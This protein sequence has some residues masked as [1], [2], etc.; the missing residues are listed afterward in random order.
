MGEIWKAAL[1]SLIVVHAAACGQSALD[2]PS[3]PDPT[4]DGADAS[5][6]QALRRHGERLSH[7]L[8]CVGCHKSDFTG[9]PF[10]QG[11]VAPNLSLMIADYDDAAL[12]RAIRQG[13]ARDGRNIKMMPSEMYHALSDADAR[14]LI[15]FL[16]TIEPA[17][18]VRPAFEPFPED[19]IQWEADG[20][21][22]APT[23]IREWNAAPGPL[24]LEP[25][26]KRGRYLAKT[27]CTEC[28]NN[29]LQ[30][31]P[32]F[33]PDLLVV[34][35]YDDDALRRLLYEGKGKTRERLGLMSLV[36]PA[37]IPYLTD[38]EYADLTAYL[39]ARAQ[40]LGAEEGGG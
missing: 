30:G 8:G 39:K 17:G 11:W 21:S 20:Y 16:R 35:D 15:S 2:P 14:A 24:E 33:T 26:Y 31:Y 36:S 40:K 34:A 12:D 4:F 6:A 1:A 27:L 38:S 23:L 37:R 22:D 10:N 5:S 18:A 25:A 7:A 3:F 19:L 28:H 29:R 13:V 32:G 9:G